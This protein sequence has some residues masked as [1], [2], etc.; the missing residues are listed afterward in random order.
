MHALQGGEGAPM[1]TATILCPC[2]MPH[3]TH[4]LAQCAHPH[5]TQALAHCFLHTAT[6]HT[7]IGPLALFSQT[8]R[9]AIVSSIFLCNR[10]IT[11][12]SNEH[13]R[14][15]HTRQTRHTPQKQHTHDKQL[16]TA[17]FTSCGN[18]LLP[19]CLPPVCRA[20]RS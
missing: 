17:H 5:F 12:N 2:T 13:F 10:Y 16:Q 9:S 3:F 7:Y 18:P 1:H 11:K 4:A 14:T 15:W 19:H 6:L 20:C 8:S